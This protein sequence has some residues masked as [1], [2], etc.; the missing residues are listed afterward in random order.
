MRALITSAVAL[1][2]TLGA[3]SATQ[4]SW[5]IT[6]EVEFSAASSADTGSTA[7]VDIAV[8]ESATNIDVQVYGLDGMRVGDRNI[9]RLHRDRLEAGSSVSF[10]VTI[11]PVPG[12][13]I[14]VVLV[15]A[16]F[17]H[18]GDGSIV[19]SYPFGEENA[20]QQAE[21][22][23]CVRQDPDGVW[24][25]DPDCGAPLIAPPPGVPPA[26]AG[27]SGASATFD[28]TIAQLKR[29][30]PIGQ[31][32][33]VVGYV[34]GSYFCPPCPEGAECKPCSSESAIFIADAPSSSLSSSAAFATIAASNPAQ[35]ERARQ[36]RF[37]IE[38]VGQHDSG[39]D[40]R[41]LRSQRSDQ[42]IWAIDRSP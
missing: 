12:R 41:L 8:S 18:M 42:P 13:S 40:A 1:L 37:E 24:I 23:R 4:P 27:A 19:R 20:A 25:R 7:I 9:A 16:R 10:P 28:L 14:I 22:S 26:Q 32:V 3:A 29:S 36:Y 35:F 15:R 2:V 31:I 5:P 6:S 11:H 34:I 38:V 30:P 33:R 17:A 21:H 39:V